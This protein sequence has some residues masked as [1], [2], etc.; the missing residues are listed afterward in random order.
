MLYRSSSRRATAC[1]SSGPANLSR[2]TPM[3]AIFYPQLLIYQ[4]FIRSRRISRTLT[5]IKLKDLACKS[6]KNVISDSLLRSRRVG[7]FIH[8]A[9]RLSP[10]PPGFHVLHEQ[11]CRAVFVAE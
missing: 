7:V 6:R 2:V 8:T 3:F 5:G 10:Q 1:G 11:R 9:P 4:D